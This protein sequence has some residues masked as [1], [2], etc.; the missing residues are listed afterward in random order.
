MSVKQDSPVVRTCYTT[1]IRF[2]LK[3]IF[4]LYRPGLKTDEWNGA[5][6]S[7]G[8]SLLRYLHPPHCQPVFI[9]TTLVTCHIQAVNW[10]LR[11]PG[12]CVVQLR[13]LRIK[14]RVR[15]QY[16]YIDTFLLRFSSLFTNKFQFL[17]TEI[18]ISEWQTSLALLCVLFFKFISAGFTYWLLWMQPK[19]IRKNRFEREWKSYRSRIECISWKVVQTSGT[20]FG[21]LTSFSFTLP[22]LSVERPMEWNTHIV[23]KT[24]DHSEFWMQLWPTILL[25]K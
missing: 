23:K 12:C 18:C 4:F 2:V 3:V 6:N 24:S 25:S 20:E 16:Q 5:K 13:L 9:F 8:G 14:D 7:E 10:C 15:I 17:F 21:I 1:L 22:L 11:M 19:R